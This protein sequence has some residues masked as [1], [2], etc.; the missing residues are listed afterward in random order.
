MKKQRFFTILFILTI[1][2]VAYKQAPL[3]KQFKEN[4]SNTT[5][6]AIISPSDIKNSNLTSVDSFSD[7]L[8]AWE[9]FK[10][11]AF[12]KLDA[13]AKMIIQLKVTIPQGSDNTKRDYLKKISDFERR[14]DNLRNNLQVIKDLANESLVIFKNNFNYENAALVS[15]MQVLVKKTDPPTRKK[16]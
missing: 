6:I 4:K 11:I 12:D 16:Q 13:N 5:P 2:F 9:A 15:E 1:A 3:L 14:N 7:S 8:S 10:K